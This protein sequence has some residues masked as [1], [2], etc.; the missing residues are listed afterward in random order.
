MVVIVIIAILAGLS[1]TI[2]STY[3]NRAKDSR[4]TAVFEIVKSSAE[5]YYSKNGVYPTSEQLN[6]NQ[7]A[8]TNYTA[9]LNSGATSYTANLLN[10]KADVISNNNAQLFPFRSN[11][12]NDVPSG[13]VIY[14]TKTNVYGTQQTYQISSSCQLTFPSNEEPGASFVM[15]HNNYERSWFAPTWNRA[16]SQNGAVAISNIDPG[17]PAFCDFRWS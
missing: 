7:P 5:R 3:N 8:P 14:I 17:N 15:L 1:T 16:K 10:I 4:A 13:K 6:N 9:S 12:D 2:Y 11:I